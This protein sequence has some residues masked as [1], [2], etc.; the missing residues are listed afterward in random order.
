MFTDFGMSEEVWIVT[1][2]DA[3]VE[4]SIVL[5]VVRAAILPVFLPHGLNDELSGPAKI[6]VGSFHYLR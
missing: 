6:T 1:L 4:F 3:G 5:A 2:V